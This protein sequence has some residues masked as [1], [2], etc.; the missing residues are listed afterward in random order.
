MKM[1]EG[2]WLETSGARYGCCESWCV[3]KVRT[4]CMWTIASF[5]WYAGIV[6]STESLKR[7]IYTVRRPKIQ[8]NTAAL[9]TAKICCCVGLDEYSCTYSKW[10]LKAIMIC[11]NFCRKASL[12]FEILW[13]RDPRLDFSRLQNC[14]MSPIAVDALSGIY[15]VSTNAQLIVGFEE[16]SYLCWPWNFRSR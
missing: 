10:L 15:V 3:W 5:A 6:I 16:Y 13:S 2:S 11:V 12:W 8:G 1:R 9:L 7:R 14:W 4:T